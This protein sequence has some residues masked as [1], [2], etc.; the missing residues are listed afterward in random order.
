M[1]PPDTEVVAAETTAAAE[2][3]ALGAAPISAEPVIPHHHGIIETWLA[4]LIATLP[5]LR[6][7]EAYNTLRVAIEALKSRL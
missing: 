3:V 5:Q 6:E 1:C 7:T 4:D 2:I